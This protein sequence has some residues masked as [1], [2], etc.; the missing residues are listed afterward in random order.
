MHIKE[1]LDSLERLEKREWQFGSSGFFVSLVCLV[2]R[3]L[4]NIYYR[5]ITLI[6]YKIN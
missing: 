1:K 2:Q 6:N 4:M 5:F 3:Y